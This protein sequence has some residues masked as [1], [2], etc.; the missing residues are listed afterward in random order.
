[1]LFDCFSFDPTI[2]FHSNNETK[3]ELLIA[4]SVYEEV[5]L[6]CVCNWN[7]TKTTNSAKKFRSKAE[8]QV[9]KIEKY[10]KSIQEDQSIQEAYEDTN[11]SYLVETLWNDQV[12]QK[13]CKLKAIGEGSSSSTSISKTLSSSSSTENNKKRKN[14]SGTLTKNK[15]R[16]ITKT[17]SKKLFEKYPDGSDEEEEEN[18]NMGKQIIY[19]I[20]KIFSQN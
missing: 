12:F 9:R 17:K 6:I 19:F 5:P 10:Q 11:I 4:I 14:K 8:A 1:M 20:N 2:A 16:R 15:K 7:R 18:E 13:I 3:S